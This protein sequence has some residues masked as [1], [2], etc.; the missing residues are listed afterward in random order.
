MKYI[1]NFKNGLAYGLFKLY[2]DKDNFIEPIFDGL[3]LLGFYAL[4]NLISIEEA[5]HR[6]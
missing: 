3:D 1:G 5:L 4:N 2:R 6:D